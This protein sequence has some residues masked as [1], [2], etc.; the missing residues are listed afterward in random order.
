MILNVRLEHFDFDRKQRRADQLPHDIFEPVGG[1]QI[2]G[3]QV[4]VMIVG[5]EGREKRQARDVIDMDMGEEEIEFLGSLILDQQIPE[6]TDPGTPVENQDFVA[7]P[8]FHTGRIAAIAVGIRTGT[9]DATADPPE[10]NR[11]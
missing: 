9:R 5:K 3:P 8:D 6:Q 1:E 7:A 2:A 11:N 4:Q 10:A